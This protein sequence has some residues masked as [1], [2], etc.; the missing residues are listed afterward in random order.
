MVISLKVCTHKFSVAVGNKT[1]F[2]LVIIC[3]YTTKEDV[4]KFPSLNLPSVR[5]WRTAVMVNKLVNHAHIYFIYVYLVL[6]LSYVFCK[7]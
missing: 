5:G 7:L 4:I 2:Y 3:H 6:T 1:S